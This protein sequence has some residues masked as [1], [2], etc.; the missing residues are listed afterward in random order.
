MEQVTECF[1]N[2]VCLARRNWTH[3]RWPLSIGVLREP[4]AKTRP[5]GNL[6][7]RRQNFGPANPG[8]ASACSGVYHTGSELGSIG[9]RST[10]TVKHANL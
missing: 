2:T 5:R 6:V 10:G 1:S 7:R 3:V 9:S 4:A 8:P